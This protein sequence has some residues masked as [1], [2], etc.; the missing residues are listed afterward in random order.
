[1]YLKIESELISRQ[2]VDNKHFPVCFINYK[3]DEFPIGTW[4]IKKEL[5]EGVERFF[6]IMLPNNKLEGSLRIDPIS[7]GEIENRVGVKN[8]VEDKLELRQ[9]EKIIVHHDET[10][11]INKETYTLLSKENFLNEIRQRSPIK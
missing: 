1:M 6:L 3:N 5:S 9:G 7:I 8:F 4:S 10:K 11:W 2:G